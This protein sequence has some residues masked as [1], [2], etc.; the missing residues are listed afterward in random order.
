MRRG[1]QI[2]GPLED[3]GVMNIVAYLWQAITQPYVIAGTIL[4]GVFFFA[5]LT[6]LGW[7]DLTVAF[8]L[9]ALEYVFAA[10]LAVVILKERVP[11]LRWLGIALVVVQPARGLEGARAAPPDRHGLPGLPAAAEQD[12]P[13]NVAF[14]LQVI[15]KPRAQINQVVPETLEMVGLEG[16]GDRMPDELS[17]GEQQRVA[18][19]RAFVNRPMILIADEPTGNLDPNTSVG[20]MKLLD[21]INRTGTTV[22]M[23]THDA[24]IVDQMRKRVIELSGGHVVRDQS[25]GVYGYQH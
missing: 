24:G 3:Y 13:E 5:L 10:F 18:I 16:K 22:L 9:T 8:P 7:T 21:R 25:R 2:V 11:A 14:A 1:M 12:R 20:I 19:A 17:G 6:A 23:A 4:S 15:G